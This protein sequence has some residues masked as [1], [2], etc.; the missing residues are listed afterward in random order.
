MREGMKCMKK[1]T[2][3]YVI[4]VLN[5]LHLF[6]QVLPVLLLLF[7]AAIPDGGFREGFLRGAGMEGFSITAETAGEVIGSVCVPVIVDIIIFV[8]LTKRKFVLLL[9]MMIVQCIAGITACG[10]IVLSVIMVILAFAV[11]SNRRYL[12]NKVGEEGEIQK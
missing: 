7:I 3:I 12:Q 1:P 11:G 2:G 4:Y 10:S 8:A 5:A 6:F 9:V